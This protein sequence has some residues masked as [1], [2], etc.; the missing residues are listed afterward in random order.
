MLQFMKIK[1]KV[2]KA[3]LENKIQ[4]SLFIVTAVYTKPHYILLV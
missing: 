4:G 3:I 2:R 1:I